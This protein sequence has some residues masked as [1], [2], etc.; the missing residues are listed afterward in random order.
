MNRALVEM[1]RA[2]LDDSVIDQKFWEQAVLM[3]AYLANRM[4]T[5]ALEVTLYELFTSRKS[6]GESLMKRT[7]SAMAGEDQSDDEFKSFIEDEEETQAPSGAQ[8][9]ASV[10][11][12][13]DG[14]PRWTKR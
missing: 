7:K 1:A 6:F 12:G 2:M 13:I 3:V 8:A 9:R 5:S 4:P 14:K 10:M 11:T